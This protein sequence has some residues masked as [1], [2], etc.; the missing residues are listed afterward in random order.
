M[1]KYLPIYVFY[2]KTRHFCLSNRIYSERRKRKIHPTGSLDEENA[3]KVME[4]LHK[5]HERG[6]SSIIVTHDKR[7]EKRCEK[8]YYLE[9]G[10]LTQI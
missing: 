9:K 6:N 7:I 5:L 8:I 10:Q 4:T 1:V 3:E 2:H